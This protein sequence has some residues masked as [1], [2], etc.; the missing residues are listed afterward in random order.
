MEEAKKVLQ[1]QSEKEAELDFQVSHGCLLQT[2]VKQ[3]QREKKALNTQAKVTEKLFKRLRLLYRTTKN[4]LMS[5]KVY[6]SNPF[7]DCSTGLN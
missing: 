5:N 7:S 3:I 4:T 1:E 2:Q 6:S